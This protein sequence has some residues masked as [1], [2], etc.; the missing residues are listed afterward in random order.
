MFFVTVI[1][2]GTPPYK[3]Q[4]CRVFLP[5]A[6][7]ISAGRFLSFCLR[8][9]YYVTPLRYSGEVQFQSSILCF[10]VPLQPV[11]VG[12]TAVYTANSGWALFN[13]PLLWDSGML[14]ARKL[15]MKAE[16]KLIKF[17]KIKM[18]LVTQHE[19]KMTENKPCLW[20]PVRFVFACAPFVVNIWPLRTWGSLPNLSYFS[21]LTSDLTLTAKC[22]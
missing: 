17:N 15:W 20:L 12:V 18:R 4:K 16:A 22:K 7:N 3:T 5:F 1:P 10:S 9:E 6:L 11:C 19:V 8:A 2:A 13:K 14:R 21:L